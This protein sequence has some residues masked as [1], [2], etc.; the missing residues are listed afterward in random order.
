MLSDL[1]ETTT[2]TFT[3]L[4][5]EDGTRRQSDRRLAGAGRL[6]RFSSQ[7]PLEWWHLQPELASGPVRLRELRLSDAPS[8]I[9]TLG[10]AK[11]AEYLSPGPASVAEIEE[12]IAWTHFA[13]KAGRYICF[14]VIP[15]GSDA[16]VGVFQL[17]PIEPSFRTAEWGFAIAH[18]FWGTGLFEAGARLVTAFAFGTLGVLRLEARAAVDNVRGNAALEKLGAVVPEGVLRKC[19]LANGEC[20]DHM[21]WSILAE[22]WRAAHG[23]VAGQVTGQV[24]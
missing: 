17:W 20:R 9:E 12:F 7:P 22:D 13:H 2:G 16:A 24:V 6:P 23:D 5:P 1:H 11:V 3:G 14:G 21:M 19:F 8:L 15:P 18:R 4:D 10:C